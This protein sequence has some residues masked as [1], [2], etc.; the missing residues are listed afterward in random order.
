[1]EEKEKDQ[2]SNGIVIE[3]TKKEQSETNIVGSEEMELNISHILE[4]I[5]RFTQLVT[6]INHNSFDFTYAA[7]HN[8]L[9]YFFYEDFR[10][11]RIRED[12]KE[13][14]NEF[15]ER[16]FMMH[17]EQMEKCDKVQRSLSSIPIECQ[18]N[19]SSQMNSNNLE[20]NRILNRKILLEKKRERE[21]IC[22]EKY[23]L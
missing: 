20:A 17:K 6:I 1:M 16:L 18:M 19:S 21:R 12:F 7:A 11:T 10:A 14:S 22:R 5:E 23:Y 15:E 4:K 2:I 8:Y 13:L 9:N 3:I